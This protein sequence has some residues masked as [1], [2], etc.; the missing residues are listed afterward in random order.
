[1]TTPALYRQESEISKT[2]TSIFT[3]KGVVAHHELVD[4]PDT[5]TEED[6]GGNVGSAAYEKSKHMELVSSQRSIV[7]SRLTR[8]LSPC[9]DSRPSEISPAQDRLVHFTYVFDNADP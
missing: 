4:V 9:L 6:E 8:F 1:M 5:I 7:A 3:E 2:D